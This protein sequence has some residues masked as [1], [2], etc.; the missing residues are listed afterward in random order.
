MHITQI[1][2]DGFKSYS[3]LTQIKGFDSQFN[4]VTG[5][6]GSG[7]SNILDAICFVFGIQSLRLVRATNLKELI[8]KQGTAKV[9]DA[10]VTI[11][12]DNSDKNLSPAN[13]TEMDKIEVTREITNMEKSKYKINGKNQPAEKVKSLFLSVHLNVNNPHFLVM[14]GKITQVVKMKPKQILSLIEETSGTALFEKRKEECLKMLTRKELTL[15]SIQE[16]IETQIEPQRVKMAES[17]ESQMVYEENDKKIQELDREIAYTEYLTL[18][19]QAKELQDRNE[20][21]GAFLEE[22]RKAI[23]DFE[24]EAKQIKGDITKLVEAEHKENADTSKIFGVVNQNEE[25]VNICE[26]DVREKTISINADKQ[27]I[28][29]IQGKIESESLLLERYNNNKYTLKDKLTTLEGE[30]GNRENDLV[31]IN[32]QLRDAKNSGKND[33]GEYREQLE[34]KIKDLGLNIQK[35]DMEVKNQSSK[36]DKKKIEQDITG[37]ESRLNNCDLSVKENV[38]RHKELTSDIEAIKERLKDSAVVREEINNWNA[39]KA[40]LEELKQTKRQ[41]LYANQNLNSVSNMTQLNYDAPPGFNKDTVL[42]RVINLFSV[43]NEKHFTPLEIIGGMQLMNIVVSDKSVSTALLKR[44]SFK[45]KVSFIPLRQIQTR[46]TDK[47]V[48]DRVESKYKGKVIHA[49]KTVN[50]S[51]DTYKAI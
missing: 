33:T 40:T 36:S 45:Q 1:I 48:V 20:A 50:Y 25:E 17:R 32:E 10:R 26:E 2:I 28:E 5:A 6:N 27:K 7:K 23:T 39:Q 30:V 21:D 37:L 12:F 47:S 43:K 51:Q 49:M 13:Y 29:E 38:R 8:Y 11:V 46:E 44:K 24:A 31:Q 16:T 19:I 34:H 14:Q 15:R 4:A 18:L 22:E 3:E 41:Q 42:G 35:I 9:K